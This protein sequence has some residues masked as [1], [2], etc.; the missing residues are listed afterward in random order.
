MSFKPFIYLVFEEI[1]GNEVNKFHGVFTTYDLA[2]EYL[3]SLPKGSY[4]VAHG[5][6]NEPF[7]LN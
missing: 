1:T 6:H 3:E 4:F 2:E 5:H 7:K